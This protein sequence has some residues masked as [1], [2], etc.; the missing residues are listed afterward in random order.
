MQ[1][2]ESLSDAARILGKTGAS[3]GGKA[4][5]KKLTP[6]QRSEIARKAVKARWAKSRRVIVKLSLTAD[7]GEK[8]RAK[9]AASGESVEEWARSV[10]LERAGAG[11]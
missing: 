3:K 2:D 11:P 9:A 4:R 6:L 8:V 5:S 10:L 7:E 1:N